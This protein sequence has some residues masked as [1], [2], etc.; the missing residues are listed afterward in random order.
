VGGEEKVGQ[1]SKG[2][3]SSEVKRLCEHLNMSDGN[4]GAKSLGNWFPNAR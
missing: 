2:G 4:V 3:H 1:S